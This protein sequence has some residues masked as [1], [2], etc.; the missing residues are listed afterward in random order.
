MTKKRSVNG[1]VIDCSC[2]MYCDPVMTISV[3]YTA[4]WDKGTRVK[5][6]LLQKP[7][8]QPAAVSKEVKQNRHLC[9]GIEAILSQDHGHSAE[10]V[11]RQLVELL[12]HNA[13]IIADE[14]DDG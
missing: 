14:V 10:F 7:K 4:G 11:R 8:P 2:A 9:L 12:R 13:D 1:T 5:V 3:P 6:T